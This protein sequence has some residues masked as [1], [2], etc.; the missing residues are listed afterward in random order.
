MARKGLEAFAARC[1]VP[2][3]LFPRRGRECRPAGSPTRGRDGGRGIPHQPRFSPAA[4][5]CPPAVRA[6]RGPGALAQPGRGR[7]RR[8]PPDTRKS[9]ARLRAGCGAN[10]SWRG[11]PHLPAWK[12]G[13]RSPPRLCPTSVPVPAG[14]HGRCCPIPEKEGERPGCPDGTAPRPVGLQRRPGPRGTGLWERDA[15]T[16][17]S[18]PLRAVFAPLLPSSAAL[19]RHELALTRR[20]GSSS[21]GG[22]PRRAPTPPLFPRRISEKGR[23]I[24]AVD[25]GGSEA[26][27][28]RSMPRGAAPP[29]ALSPRVPP[30]SHEADTL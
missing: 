9:T 13:S 19:G 16:R 4:A 10:L 1:K 17:G 28:L 18:L 22:T 30:D 20:T 15:P 26:A 3:P 6:P 12:W 27:R 11:I 24:T 29:P 23:W 21:R 2:R 7:L 25:S 14:R 5:R 8:H